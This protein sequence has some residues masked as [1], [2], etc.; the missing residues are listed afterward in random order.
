MLFYSYLKIH[1]YYFEFIYTD[2]TDLYV[3]RQSSVALHL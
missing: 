3:F 1:V 2:L